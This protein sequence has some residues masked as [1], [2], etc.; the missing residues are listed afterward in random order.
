MIEHTI[1]PAAALFSGVVFNVD[2]AQVY[3]SG[4][5]E[6]EPGVYRNAAKYLAGLFKVATV[7]TNPTIETHSAGD[8]SGE[9]V[10]RCGH[11]QCDVVGGSLF[12]G[13]GQVLF[14][15][16]SETVD[17][18]G[19]EEVVA[20]GG[21]HAE[22]EEALSMSVVHIPRVRIDL[23]LRRRRA[24]SRC[25]PVSH[26]TTHRGRFPARTHDQLACEQWRLCA[27]LQS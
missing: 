22:V 1:A 5:A 3:T 13:E 23:D 20:V 17:D 18:G 16:E 15:P 24:C 19:E 7:T 2:T 12:D 9:D 6:K 21:S 8:Q 11:Q 26:R 25:M 10:G 27:S 4:L 14:D